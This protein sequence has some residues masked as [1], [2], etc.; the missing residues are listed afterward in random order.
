MNPEKQRI[1][2]AESCGW[3]MIHKANA[4]AMYGSWVGYPPTLPILN[5]PEPIPR[6][7][8][9]LNAMYLAEGCLSD[10]QWDSYVNQL[11]RELGRTEAI[12]ADAETRAKAFLQTIG[13]WEQTN[14]P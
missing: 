1:V 14:E 3:T 11:T 12:H 13:K 9:D 5:K 6:Y 10:E 8:T 7:T 2:I 4:M